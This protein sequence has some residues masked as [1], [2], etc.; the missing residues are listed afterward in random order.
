MLGLAAAEVFGF[1][2]ERLTPLARRIGPTPADLGQS[3]DQ[4]AVAASWARSRAVG[5]HWLTDH[6]FPV[7]G[8]TP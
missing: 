4:T 2:V 8:T 7:L 6:D 1:D 5:R 3:D